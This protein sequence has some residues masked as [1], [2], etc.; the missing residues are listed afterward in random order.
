MKTLT[1]EIPD[2]YSASKESNTGGST[3][4]MNIVDDSI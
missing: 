1:R 4:T 2:M 3:M